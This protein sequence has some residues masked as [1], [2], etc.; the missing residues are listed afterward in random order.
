VRL[1]PVQY[2][3]VGLALATFYLLL[4]ALSEHAGFSASY[5][6]AAAALV[7]LVTTYL[8][9]ATAKRKTAALIGAGLAASYAALFVILLS[10]DY[11]LLFGSLLLFLIL[12]ALML[13][14]RRLN[15]ARLGHEDPGQ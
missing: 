5:A 14:T 8:A 7:T 11:A 6:I 10:A 3:L 1:H 13:T 4:L 9:G 12:A 15:W 2:L